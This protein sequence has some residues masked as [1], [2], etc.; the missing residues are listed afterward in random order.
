MRRGSPVLGPWWHSVRSRP[1]VLSVPLTLPWRGATRRLGRDGR[2]LRSPARGAPARGFR[3]A[4]TLTNGAPAGAM[5]PSEPMARSRPQGAWT[6]TPGAGPILSSPECEL[7]G[8]WPRRWISLPCPAFDHHP[9]SIGVSS[10]L[11]HTPAGSGL[12]V[13]LC[14]SVS[15]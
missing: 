15:P 4:R 1:H 8:Q 7:I 14:G 6:H 2:V 12:R 9:L 10:F 5:L 3:P 13:P 11:S